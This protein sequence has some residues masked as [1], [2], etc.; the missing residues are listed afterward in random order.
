MFMRFRGGGVGHHYMREV[1]PWLDSTGWGA[2]WPVLDGRDPEP[3]VDNTGGGQQGVNLDAS[4]TVQVE[5]GGRDIS[6]SQPF[7]GDREGVSHCKDI[8]NNT[9]MMQLEGME[10]VGHGDVN[11]SGEDEIE[12]E[13]DDDLEN[14]MEQEEILDCSSDEDQEQVEE[15]E[16]EGP[17]S[18]DDS[19]D[20]VEISNDDND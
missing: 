8:A 10:S 18:S 14:P 9:G 20:E 4:D 17:D 16:G 2:S 5:D 15:R 1:E 19:E 3:D 13:D 6:Q 7:E 12:E 11:D